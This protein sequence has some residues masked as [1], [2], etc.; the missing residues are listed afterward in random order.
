MY[1]Y[2]WVLFVLGYCDVGVVWS[3]YVYF[4]YFFGL[5][6]VCECMVDEYVVDFLFCV[7]VLV[8]ML[9][10]GFV[11]YWVEMV[12]CDGQDFGCWE[13]QCLCIEG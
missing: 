5:C 12:G 3:C 11:C 8:W 1:L 7:E 10:Y 2:L 4:G 9:F 6:E 13:Q